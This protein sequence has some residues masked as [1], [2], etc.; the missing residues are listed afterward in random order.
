MTRSNRW[1]MV[2]IANCQNVGAYGGSKAK[3]GLRKRRVMCVE[4][5][6]KSWRQ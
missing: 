2:L 1:H 6:E 3:V 5:D 4:E